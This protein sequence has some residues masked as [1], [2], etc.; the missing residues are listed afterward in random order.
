MSSV[1]Q[2]A[3]PFTSTA[4]LSNK[5]AINVIYLGNSMLERLKTTGKTTKLAGLDVAWNAGCGGD[6]NENVVYR[7][8][9]PQGLYSIL[10]F[11]HN[12]EVKEGE[13]R[14]CDIKLWVLASGTNNL[15]PKRGLRDEDV[16]SWRVLVQSCLSIAPGSQVVACDVFHR[17]DIEDRLV[18]EGNE[19]LRRVVEE[20]NRDLGEDKVKWVEARHL[21]SKEM[22]VDHVHLNEEGYGVWDRVLWPYVAE[23]LGMEREDGS[24]S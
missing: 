23:A 7:L 3:D 16:K 24:K 8:S 1:E 11:A 19:N 21:I 10:K 6:K 17:K 5:T 15:H 4:N 13:E 2:G 18:D 14:K 12:D 20:L 22:L 9:E